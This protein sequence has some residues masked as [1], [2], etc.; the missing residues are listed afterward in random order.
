MKFADHWAAT[1]DPQARADWEALLTDLETT[2]ADR[3]RALLAND[4]TD[5]DIEIS[6]LRD[7]LKME[8]R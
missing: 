8:T 5:L 6:V 7:R 3:S 2:F 4:R 1:R